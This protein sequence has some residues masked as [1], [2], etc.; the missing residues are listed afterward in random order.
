M[1]NL[2]PKLIENSLILNNIY[3]CTAVSS[4]VKLENLTLL[5]YL[6]ELPFD[7][8]VVFIKSQ[9][10]NELINLLNIC[11]FLHIPKF[12]KT[13]GKEIA[14]RMNKMSKQFIK[15]NLVFCHV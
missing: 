4:V 2:S 7:S 15:E 12:L 11:D 1:A 10:T 5:N 13:I 3:E 9:N 14:D 8:F 6:C